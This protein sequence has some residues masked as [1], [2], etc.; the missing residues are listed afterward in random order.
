MQL[1]ATQPATQPMEKC[2][3]CIGLRSVTFSTKEKS[4][5]ALRTVQK[6]VKAQWEVNNH[7]PSR[8]FEIR[9]KWHCTTAVAW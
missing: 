5:G 8:V 9:D 4:P 7:S 6:I 3:E 2:K 1:L